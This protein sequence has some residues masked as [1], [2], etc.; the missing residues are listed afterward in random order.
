MK[1]IIM[2]V[3]SA[4]ATAAWAQCGS[5]CSEPKALIESLR[6]SEFLA[7]ANRMML[8][9]EGKKSCCRTTASKAV[10]KGDAGCCNA[11]GKDAKFKV[12]VA[13]SYQYF[14]CEGSASKARSEMVGKGQRV[15]RVQPV[16]GRVRI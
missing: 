14:G 1:W 15:G 16:T 9:S 10:A 7:E 12:F 2:M 4:L 11:K 3:V 6:E 13:G 5:S 8:A